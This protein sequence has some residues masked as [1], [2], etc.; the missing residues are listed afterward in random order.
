MMCVCACF[1]FRC[2]FLFLVN[3]FFSLSKHTLNSTWR[4]LFL[5]TGEARV[6]A[7]DAICYECRRPTHSHVVGRSCFFGIRLLHYSVVAL[8]LLL[9]LRLSYLFFFLWPV[10]GQVWIS[11]LSRVRPQGSTAAERP[12][13]ISTNIRLDNIS[14][15]VVLRSGGIVTTTVSQ[16]RFFCRGWREDEG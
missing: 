9:L 2:F 12:P 15:L 4:L 10:R 14:A 11:E 6:D 3:C 1:C 5:L 13:Y 16:L 7:F 8:P